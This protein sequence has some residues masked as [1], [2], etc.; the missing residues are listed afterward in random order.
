MDRKWIAVMDEDR[1]YSTVADSRGDWIASCG[2]RN[3]HLIA[4]APD[5]YEALEKIATGD[6]VYGDQ[7]YEYK[8]IARAALA[9]ARGEA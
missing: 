8:Q 9:K 2:P 7:A 1:E 3:A 4:A 6:G 5:L